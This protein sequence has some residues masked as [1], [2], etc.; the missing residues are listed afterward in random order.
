MLRRWV[1]AIG[2]AAWVYLS[3]TAMAAPPPVQLRAA[4]TPYRL[5]AP[6]T[7]GF[8]LQIGAPAGTAPPALTRLNVQ[9]PAELGIALSELGLVTCEQSTLEAA[10]P[11]HCPAESRMGLGRVVAELMIEGLLV[12]EPAKVTIFRAPQAGGKIR[13]LLY[14]EALEPIWAELPF[15]GKLTDGSTPRS[16]GI[17]INVPLVEGVR[18]GPDVAI[19]K[20]DASLGPRSLVYYERRHGQLVPYRPRGILLPSRCPPGGFRFSAEAA[21]QDGSISR[22][23]ARVGC[24]RSGRS[25]AG[26]PRP[27]DGPRGSR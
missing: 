17:E 22:A 14:A 1:A 4:F 12:S 3:G 16:E 24:L 13:L 9:Y 10:G 8:S 11:D 25:G 27:G 21:F 23:R 15:Y 19:V 2:I 26:R 5:G 7:V 18:G 6:T 20:L